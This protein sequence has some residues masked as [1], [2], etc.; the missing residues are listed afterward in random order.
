MAAASNLCFIL[1]G[2]DCELF[3]D[4]EQN[5]TTLDKNPDGVTEFNP[6]KLYT[7]K[8]Q[9]EFMKS[10]GKTLQVYR[11]DFKIWRDKLP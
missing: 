9:I 6:L 4:G 2:Q 7:S 3:E 11:D 8:Q 5:F 10:K 1:N